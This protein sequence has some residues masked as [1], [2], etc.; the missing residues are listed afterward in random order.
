LGRLSFLLIIK[1]LFEIMDEFMGVIK[2][3]AGNFAPKGWMF[4]NGQI[5]SINSNQALF[6]LIGTT[7]G[8]DGT[9]TFAL[10]D[11]RSRVPIGAGQGPGLSNYP[12]GQKGGAE[13]V[14][15]LE[16]QMPAHSH[17]VTLT[18]AQVSI[19]VTAIATLNGVTASGNFPATTV[20]VTGGEVTI[21]VNTTGGTSIRHTDPSKGL[22]APTAAAAYSTL[23]NGTYGGKGTLTKG[24]V[25]IPQTPLKLPVSGSVS[26]P[27]KAT[28]NVTGGSATTSPTGG[29][30]GVDVRSP[31]LGLNY[32]I[33]LYGIYPPRD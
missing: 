27:I 13:Q 2:L 15:L 30:Q 19:N 4:C 28:T 1:K 5:L 12:Q 31:Y 16:A 11:L 6:S 20:P 21:P 7:Y 24:D 3:F 17:P 9:T 10:P 22:L 8:G 14:T 33:C 23:S 29:K 25:N 26:V 32:I 18:G